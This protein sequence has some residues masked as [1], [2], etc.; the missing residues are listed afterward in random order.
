M[1]F[2]DRFSKDGRDQRAREKNAARAINKYMQSPD[3]MK[4]LQALRDDGSD[5]ALFA[6][7]KRFGMMYDKTIEDEQEKE[8]AFDALVELGGKVLPALKRYLE[9]AESIS[10]PLRLLEKVVATKDEQIDVVAA[11]LE[12]H[13]PGYERDPT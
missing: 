5:D 10:W 9:S 11:A 7:M 12:R 6:L 1:G 2:L 3:R 4:A 8:W 13:E